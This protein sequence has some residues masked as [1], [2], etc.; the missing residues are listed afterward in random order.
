MCEPI[1]CAIC[2]KPVPLEEG[3]TDCT[4]KAVHENCYASMLSTQLPAH[5]AISPMTLAC[6]RC[7]AEPAEACEVFPNG[8]QGVH[9]ERI[10]LAATMDTHL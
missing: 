4:G 5:M 10:K 2:G 8:F 1:L 6:P 7:N 9:I 3:K